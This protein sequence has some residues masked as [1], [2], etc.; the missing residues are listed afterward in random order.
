V[1]ILLRKKGKK[2]P[3]EKRKDKGKK[4][5]SYNIR[6]SYHIINMKTGKVVRSGVS[7]W[8]SVNDMIQDDFGEETY[9]DFYG[10]DNQARLQGKREKRTTQEI[11]AEIKETKS[12]SYSDTLKSKDSNWWRWMG[13]KK[14]KD[15]YITIYRGVSKEKGTFKDEIKSG[16]WVT[17]DKKQAKELYAQFHNGKV[18]SKRVKLEDLREAST[19]SP[20]SIELIYQKEITTPKVFITRS[21]VIQYE[22]S[23]EELANVLDLH[24]SRMHVN[25]GKGDLE[26]I[27]SIQD[28]P[29]NVRN[30]KWNFVGTMETIS[31]GTRYYGYRWEAT[32]D[33][34]PV[35]IMSRVDKTRRMNDLEISGDF[36]WSDYYFGEEGLKEAINDYHKKAKRYIKRYF[37]NAKVKFVTE[38]AD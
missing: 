32:S 27:R 28:I 26:E 12:K 36:Q 29:E 5:G 6:K 30:A 15:E 17:L 3:K 19:N 35:K 2:N 14:P 34:Y 4:R 9:T 16:D 1:I 8:E 25:N 31:G 13:I 11:L 18:L 7:N 21:P 23:T 10:T 20:R 37:P 33:I 22:G 24:E 38:E